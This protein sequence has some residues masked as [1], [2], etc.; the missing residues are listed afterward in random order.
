MIIV[1]PSTQKIWQKPL[2]TSGADIGIALDGDAD[3]LIMCDEHGTIHDGDQVIAAIATF[4]KQNNKLNN[5]GV[6][7]TVMANFGMEEYLKTQDINFV[8]TAVGDR[9]VIEAMREHGYNLG[10]EPSGH[11]IFSDYATTGDGLLAAMQVMAMMVE[12]EK[13]ASEVLSLYTPYPQEL[14]NVKYN[15]KKAKKDVL[16]L[17]KVK[18]AITDA[19]SV[20][21]DK[22]RVLIRKIG[23][24]AADSCDGGVR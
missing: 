21:G 17:P 7:S 10:G 6:V 1:A 18:S 22:G 12:S 8:R 13:P 15:P 2:K 4:W 11:I 3:R 16:E 19:E 9:Y 20:L 5:S 23:H 24:R 14:R